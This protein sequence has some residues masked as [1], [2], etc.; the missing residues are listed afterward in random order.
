MPTTLFEFHDIHGIPTVAE[1]AAIITAHTSDPRIVR[2]AG[3][4]TIV[5]RFVGGAPHPRILAYL[6]L[7]PRL[8]FIYLPGSAPYSGNV[9]AISKKIVP[10]YTI[11]ESKQLYRSGLVSR[12]EYK[13]HK[14]YFQRFQ[15]LFN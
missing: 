1:G 5:I 14:Y 2:I 13:E 9:P 11:A 3:Q 15:C 4:D 10:T 8:R 12:A 6:L 7:L